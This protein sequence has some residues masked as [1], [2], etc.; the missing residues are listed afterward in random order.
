MD[1]LAELMDFI[2]TLLYTCSI[3]GCLPTPAHRCY[4]YYMVY[5]QMR[6]V[7]SREWE[8]MVMGVSLSDMRL[9]VQRRCKQLKQVLD[10]GQGPAGTPDTDL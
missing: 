3:E 7:A 9:G 8:E 5:D 10:D 6:L 2:I 1:P 4:K